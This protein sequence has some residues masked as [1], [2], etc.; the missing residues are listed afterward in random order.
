VAVLVRQ[1]SVLFVSLLGAV[2]LLAFSSVAWGEPTEDTVDHGPAGVPYAAGELIVTFEEEAPADAVESLDEEITAE[3]EEKLPAI[4]A[5][6][7]EFPEVKDERFQDV[8]EQDLARI[9]EELEKDPAVESADYNYIYT[10]SY[11]PN[12]PKFKYQWGLKETGFQSAWNRTRG[13][14]VRVAVVDSGAGVRH[15]DLRRKVAAKRDFRNDDNTV[16][17]PNG[18]GTHLS[19]I[20][21]ARTG[22]KRGVAGGCPNCKLLIAKVMRSDGTGDTGDIAEGIIWSADSGAKVINLSLGGAAES[23]AV[24][25]AVDYATGKGAVVVAAAGNLRNDKAVPVYPAAYSNVIAVTA[26][27][28]KDRRAWFSNY[29]D[30]VDVAAPGMS[31]LSTVPGG[32]SYWGGTSMATAHVSALAGLLAAQ[33]H[34]PQAIRDRILGSALDLGPT[35]PDPY[36]GHGRIRANQATRR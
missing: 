12:D 17:D 25:N 2:A 18:H 22:N 3:V 33:G 5:R 28:K 8:R 6:L 27:N 26:T 31:I 20:V 30:W 32:Y 13:S 29:G 36:Y 10:I 24:K 16:E 34:D 4:D 35:G 9:K 7:F 1:I 21:S 11:T 14:G 23:E 15:V 19:G